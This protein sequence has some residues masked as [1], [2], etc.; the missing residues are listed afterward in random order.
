MNNAQLQ[1]ELNKAKA[2]ILELKESKPETI[3]EYSVSG[4]KDYLNNLF[5]LGKISRSKYDDFLNRM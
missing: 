5:K 4:F 1:S 3:I 2:E